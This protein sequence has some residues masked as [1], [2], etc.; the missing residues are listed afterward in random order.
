MRSPLRTAIL[1]L[2]A[3]PPTLLGLSFVVFLLLDLVPLDRAEVALLGSP[4]ARTA[5]ERVAT[6]RALRAH[7][8]ML[9]PTTGEPL[10]FTT[11]WVR[12]LDHAVRLDFAPPSEA[13][14]AF[15]ERF[16]RA[17]AIS[18]LLGSLALMLAIAVG[19]PL[20]WWLGRRVD[21]VADRLV[22]GS[23]LG[24]GA[25]PEFLVATLLVLLFGG[26]LRGLLPAGGLRTPGADAWSPIDQVADLFLHLALPVVVLAIAPAAWIARL[27]RASCARTARA[28]FVHA[29]RTLGASERFV[30]LRI[31][32]NSSSPLW[33][34]LGVLVPWIVAGAV[35]VENVFGIPG[36][37]RLSLDAI[38]ARDPS[39]V[40]AAT[41]LVASLVA[42]GGILGDL[43]HR[44]GDRRVA[45]G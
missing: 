14:A 4:Q 26:P 18:A 45:L 38:R 37:G 7:W 32:R 20:G 41:L 39:T 28:E 1:R 11:R 21:T 27:L 36:F 30:A 22:S 8:G 40:L 13:P 29:L 6:V 15:R 24:L 23:L 10:P 12:W 25:L 33:T 35:V 44:A 5:T 42:I 19:V 3:I 43:L 2:I 16:V 31:L 34:F 9:D 17:I